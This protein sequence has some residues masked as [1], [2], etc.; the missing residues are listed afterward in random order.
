MRIL[1]V[2][3]DPGL[4]ASAVDGLAAQGFTVD[5]V[6]TG[7]AALDSV[8][9]SDPSPDVI[10]LDLGL[11]DIDGQE[12][13]R[14]IRAASEVP[15]IVVSAR[16][17]EADRVIALE[18]G[19][20]DYLTKPYGMRELAARIR[21]VMRRSTSTATTAAPAS[22]TATAGGGAQELGR[23]S[24]DRRAQRV[25]IDGEEVQLTA[26]EFDVL[27]YLAEDPGAV[28]RRTEILEHVWDG[29]WYGAT[30]TVD[31]HVAAIRKKLGDP[32]WVEAVR[33][34]G[35]RLGSP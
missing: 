11:P 35:F 1:L 26:K 8:A 16:G 23:L 32:A 14:R 5:H 3:D 17:D 31:A 9:S 21:A 13:C 7:Q 34:V 2:E 33:G 24:I 28:R 29:H 10:L 19:A 20:D 25:H 4:A 22:P 12:V 6:A 30:K 18:L 27:A 15:V